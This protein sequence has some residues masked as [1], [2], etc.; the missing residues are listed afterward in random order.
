MRQET[1]PLDFG[2]GGLRVAMFLDD[3][4]M[5]AASRDG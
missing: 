4:S 3:E 5:T 2:D 1:V